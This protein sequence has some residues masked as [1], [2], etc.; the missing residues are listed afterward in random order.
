MCFYSDKESLDWIENQVWV[1]G[2]LNKHAGVDADGY[3]F[4]KA[5]KNAYFDSTSW[6]A[7]FEVWNNWETNYTS[8]KT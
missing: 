2:Y 7:G 8:P 1:T 4:P 6:G 5:K 3:F